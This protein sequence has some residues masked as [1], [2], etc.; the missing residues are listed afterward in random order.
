MKIILNNN[1]LLKKKCLNVDLKTGFKV[2][3]RIGMFLNAL[4]KKTKNKI[5]GLAANQIGVD[6]FVCQ[7]LKHT[8]HKVYTIE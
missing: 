5:D 2:A 6:A 7:V 4:K 3:K 1:E 8:E